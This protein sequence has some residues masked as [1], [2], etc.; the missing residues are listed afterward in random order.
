M[1]TPCTIIIRDH[2]GTEIILYRH[3]DGQPEGRGGVLETLRLAVPYM[4]PLDEFSAGEFAAALIRAW[5]TGPGEVR[6]CSAD[7][8]N[9]PEEP[10]STPYVYEIE[11]GHIITGQIFVHHYDMTKD[12]WESII[13]TTRM[14]GLLFPANVRGS[15]DLAQKLTGLEDMTTPELESLR[16]R[17]FDL[18]AGYRHMAK[19]TA[20]ML[21]ET[22]ARAMVW[23]DE[24]LAIYSY[25]DGLT[26]RY[27]DVTVCMDWDSVRMFAPG[28]WVKT[29]DQ[30]Y[31]LAEAKEAARKSA[32][33][34]HSRYVLIASLM[35]DKEPERDE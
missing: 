15:I 29:L 30:I 19:K 10:C 35:G 14:D 1:S 8:V 18:S 23:E 28:E 3:Y 31:P 22:R 17:V 21:G 32:A 26:I 9:F 34:R 27:N 4:K 16:L 24:S 5:K 25:S 11:P 20:D 2:D 7:S 12:H 6:I 33:E 13:S